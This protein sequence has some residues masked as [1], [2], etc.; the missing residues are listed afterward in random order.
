M[1]T[2]GQVVYTVWV[3]WTEGYPFSGLMEEDAMKF[4]HT[5]AVNMHFKV[6]ELPSCGR[7]LL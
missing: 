6:C 4:L 5:A 2:N 1:E 3:H 7:A